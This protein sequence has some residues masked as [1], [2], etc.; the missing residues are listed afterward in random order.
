LELEPFLLRLQIKN[1][2]AFTQRFLVLFSSFLW[3]SASVFAQP[4]PAAELPGT[5]LSY[6]KGKKV[7]LIVNQS[8]MVNKGHLVDFLLLNDIEVKKIFVP[9][10]GF[11]GTAD[12]GEKVDDSKDAKTG[13]PIISLYGANKKPSKEQL[14]GLDVL[15]FD[16]QDV[17]VRFYTYISTMHYAMEA[18]AEYKV[19][20][21]VLDRPN[22]NGHYVDGP[23]LDK[24]FS[25]FVGMHPIP[26]VHGLTVGELANMIVGEKW[27]STSNPLKMRV[28]PM[29]QYTHKTRYDLP[30]KPSPNLPN[31]LAIAAYPSLCLFEGTPISI[32]RGTE[33]PF[34]AIGYPNSSF[35]S[36][37]FTPRSIEGMSKNPPHENTLCYG[38]DFR[39]GH[40]KEGFTLKYLIDF[41]QKYPEK[42]KYFNAF[43]A[44]LVGTD[45]LAEQIK[46]GFTE[47]EIRL[48]WQAELAEYKRIR[49]K[50]L[51]YPDFE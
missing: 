6:L 39:K 2:M 51:L 18:C 40:W 25:S 23:I 14:S 4:I 31:A 29:E 47:E 19:E 11:R 49:K 10:H 32:A 28:I 33:F 24:K 42:E 27:L 3:V 20:F 1:L 43:F 38:V 13:L 30:V 7:G 45:Q 46:E 35:G 48:G 26:V 8:S 17:G 44:K 21:M 36:F 22:P 12:A 9:E 50:Y 15:V 5:Y 34:Q 16:L 37:T 41:Y